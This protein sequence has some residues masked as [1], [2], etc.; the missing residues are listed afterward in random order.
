LLWLLILGAL[1]LI[2]L[3]AG[4]GKTGRFWFGW[5]TNKQNSS[6]SAG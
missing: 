4:H 1:I 5:L 2:L 3:V 6:G